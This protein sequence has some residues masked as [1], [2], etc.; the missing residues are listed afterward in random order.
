MYGFFH[1]ALVAYVLQQPDGEALVAQLAD[2]VDVNPTYCKKKKGGR[3]SQ[4]TLTKVDREGKRTWSA[5]EQWQW[6]RSRVRTWQMRKLCER[7]RRERKGER[8]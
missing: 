8:K 7:E 3:R 5:F 1:E 2:L 4:P 6:W